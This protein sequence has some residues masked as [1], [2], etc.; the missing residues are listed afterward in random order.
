M[1]GP[2]VGAA[3][4]GHVVPDQQP[5]ELRRDGEVEKA[6]C[7]RSAPVGD[8]EVDHRSPGALAALLAVL[9]PIGLVDVEEV[10]V[11]LELL[12]SLVALALKRLAVRTIDTEKVCDARFDFRN[13]RIVD[14]E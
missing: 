12:A 3:V 9:L 5:A 2:G 7:S 8:I 14:V 11:L 10:G 13:K 1:L 4:E 6:K